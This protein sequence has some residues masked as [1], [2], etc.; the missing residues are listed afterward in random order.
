MTQTSHTPSRKAQGAHILGHNHEDLRVPREAI[1]AAGLL[2]ALVVAMAS[3]VSF[4]LIAPSGNPQL[5]RDAANVAPAQQRELLFADAA[6]G[7]VMVTDA[8]SGEEVLTIAYGESGFLRATVRGMA[9]SRLAAGG[10]P[11][12][13]FVLTRW[14]NGALS[15]SDPVSGRSRELIGFGENQSAAFDRLLEE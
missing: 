1:I 12:Q 11:D 9:K 7:S 2:L 10:T 4:G 8:A 6:D 5:S 13:P 14:D 15:L 3:A